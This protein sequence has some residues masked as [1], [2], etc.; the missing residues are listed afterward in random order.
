[1]MKGFCVE[2][3]RNNAL[4]LLFGLLVFEAVLCLWFV[5]DAMFGFRNYLPSVFSIG[6]EATVPSAF[7]ALQLF[8]VGLLFL[9]HG[10]WPKVQL[11]RNSGFL[12]VVGMGFL[13]LSL[14]EFATLHELLN[15]RLK[16][17]ENSPRFFRGNHGI[18]IAVYVG[19]GVLF[20]LAGLKTL[21]SMI[22]IY[23]R[24]SVLM[25]SGF[26]LAVFGGVG[27]EAVSYQFLR[28]L[29][30]GFLYRL[31]MTFEELFEMAGISLVLYGVLLC[32]IHLPRNSGL[33]RD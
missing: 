21:V 22:K 16:H 17:L 27:L 23:T 7:S 15:A 2:F 5:L 29:N 19:V 25:A 4:Q 8:V 28:N 10:M 9:C 20:L 24:P 1:M 12:F 13:F 6:G 31:E 18:W 11:V 26:F 3:T 14:D 30:R 32:A 33:V